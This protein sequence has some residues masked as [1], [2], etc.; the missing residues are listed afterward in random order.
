MK[1]RAQNN[2]LTTSRTPTVADALSE[3]TKQAAKAASKQGRWHGIEMVI[4]RSAVQNM[5][6]MSAFEQVKKVRQS[7]SKFNL[8]NLSRIRSPPYRGRTFYQQKW[9]AKSILRDYH[10][11]PVRE[12]QWAKQLFRRRLNAV[13]PMDPTYM[14]RNDGTIES[15]GRGSGLKDEDDFRGE[16]RKRMDKTIPY[17]NMT[18]A[19]LERRLDTAIFRALFASST[20]Q[21]RQFV[22]HGAVKVN[23]KKMQYPG[24]LLNPGD[25][26]QVEPQRVMFATGAP[27]VTKKS[28]ATTD[29]DSGE[30]LDEA[31]SKPVEEEPAE[32]EE[33][34]DDVDIEREP[35]E[36]LKDLMSQAKSILSH[37]R[38]KIGA[39]KKQD[40]RAFTKAVKRMLSRSTSSSVL[41]D[42]LEAQFEEIKN[43]LRIQ[44]QQ[45]KSGQ[46]AADRA[47]AAN[48]S[49]DAPLAKAQVDAEAADPVT[50]DEKA[51]A[52]D[53]DANYLS[54][55]DLKQLQL[56]FKSSSE[57]PIDPR[58]PYATPW[59]P[60]DYMSAF[61]FIPRYLEVN[62]NICAAVYLRHPVVRPGLAEVPTPYG[63]DVNGTAFTWYLRRR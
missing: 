43:Q 21:A 58:K 17:M 36:L 19:P 51:I 5:I 28:A 10:G 20:R 56:A 15:S 30:P 54:D 23:G 38:A 40:L 55:E 12:A 45:Q 47:K 26:F 63:P 25:M 33:D 27:K 11:E 24:Y 31:E 44:K 42:S 1:T 3:A 35:R 39:K 60:R 4:I 48:E 18:F 29:A 41:T 13:I 14:A 22:V 59:T 57:N 7:W 32:E 50:P 6:Q 9:T 8:Y 61:A 34:D 52:E 62:Q 46:A 16:I 37:E 2:L 53:K 49:P